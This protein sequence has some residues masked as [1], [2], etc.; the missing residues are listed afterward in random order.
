MSLDRR[1]ML[2]GT[3]ALLVGGS[4]EARG[5]AVD[6][7]GALRPSDSAAAFRQRPVGPQNLWL[8]RKDGEEIMTRFRSD[9]AYDRAAVMQLS[10][11]LRDMTDGDRAVWMSPRLLDLLAGVQSGLSRV[12]DKP[13][14]LVITSGYRTPEHNAKIE[15]AARNS[16]HLYGYAADLVAPG[17]EPRV[18]ALAASFFAGGGIGLYDDFTHLDVW[19]VRTWNGPPAHHNSPNASPSPVPGAAMPGPSAAG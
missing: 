13:V 11:F 4:A 19:K 3:A 5:F 8:R 14:P 2:A 10:W 9:A 16:M 18:V 7:A 17:Y 12:A 6:F 1:S 15:T